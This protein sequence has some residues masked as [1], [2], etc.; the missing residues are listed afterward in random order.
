MTE[1][2][3]VLVRAAGG[4]S[5]QRPD[6]I[7]ETAP[8]ARDSADG[9]M[10]SICGVVSNL[11]DWDASIYDRVFFQKTVW[12]RMSALGLPSVSVYADYL[13]AERNESEALR[14]SL[15]V[16]YSE[17]FR[18]FL[19]FAQ[20]AHTILPALI[21]EKKHCGHGGIR[22]WSAG[23][24]AGQE[25]WSVA[26]LLDEIT[27]RD[28]VPLTYRVFGTD[29]PGPDLAQAQRGCYRAESLGN[30]PMRLL[31]AYF[32]RDGESF[33]VL[34]RLRPNV[35]FSDYD[36]L[37]ET[38]V[39]PATSIYGDFDLILCC[40]VLFYYQSA[41]RRRIVEKLMRALVPG[42]YFVTGEVEREI[43]TKAQMARSVTAGGSIFQK[44]R[45]P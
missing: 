41:V 10:E 32:V 13:S 24:A 9:A 22:V 4:T 18:S 23:C 36:L 2:K 45:F 33:T 30:I 43:V 12:K 3:P 15:R 7:I 35:T 40:N 8:P 1:I 11:Y 44:E 34:P 29:L 16:G 25:A 6:L 14:V 17:F 19:T 39:C 38:S 31:N 27:V 21:R 5:S 26:I 37:D 42:G 28:L 20:L